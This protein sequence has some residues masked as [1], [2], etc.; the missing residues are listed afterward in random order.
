MSKHNELHVVVAV[1]NYASVSFG[2]IAHRRG[3]PSW[4]K[5][6]DLHFVNLY[7]LRGCIGLYIN[8]N[9]VNMY[10]RT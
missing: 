10:L 8:H 4:I 9:I 5:Y 2:H 6:H 1:Q 3:S 7:E